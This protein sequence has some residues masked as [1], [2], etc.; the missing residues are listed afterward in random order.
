VVRVTTRHQI[1]EPGNHPRHCV[2]D[3]TPVEECLKIHPLTADL[4][5]V[6]LPAA[7]LEAS[8]TRRIGN[9]GGEPFERRLVFEE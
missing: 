7:N 1:L 5:S 6:P 4:K 9:N 2:R 8:P 3:V